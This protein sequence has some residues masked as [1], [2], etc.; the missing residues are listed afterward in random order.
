MESV[1]RDLRCKCCGALLGVIDGERFEV[2]RGGLQVSYA[3]RGLIHL[4]CYVPTCR[5]LTVLRLPIEPGEV[6]A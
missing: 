3:G 1:R 6:A 5:T 2:R 4:V